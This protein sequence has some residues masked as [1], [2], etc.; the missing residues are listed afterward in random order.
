[1][2]DGFGLVTGELRAHASR[3]NGIRDQL[4]AALDAA[5][6]VSLPTEAYGQIC[7][8]FPPV[9]DPVEQSGMDAIAEAITSM[10]FTATEMRQTAEQY[11]AVDDANRQAFGP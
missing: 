1:M 10:E 3:L 6:T 4:T 2:S 7:Q 9:V 8:F 11:Q 5:R